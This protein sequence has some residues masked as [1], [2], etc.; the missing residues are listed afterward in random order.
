MPDTV[1]LKENKEIRGGLSSQIINNGITVTTQLHLQQVTIDYA[2][3]YTCHANNS[4]GTAFA[5]VD[6]II[7]GK[8]MSVIYQQHRCHQ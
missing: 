1:W 8:N 2:G 6:V 3:I 5:E 4:I 7:S